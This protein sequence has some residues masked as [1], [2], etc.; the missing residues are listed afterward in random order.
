MAD[1]S[2]MQGPLR[3]EVEA[4]L[5]GALAPLRAALVSAPS[6]AAAQIDEI[7]ARVRASRQLAESD[8][9]S[10][11]ARRGGEK[12]P[13]E[14]IA[15]ELLQHWPDPIERRGRRKGSTIATPENLAEL[16]RRIAAGQSQ[17]SAARAIFEGLPGAESKAENLLKF[18]RKNRRARGQ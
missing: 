4:D 1:Q 3:L 18:W 14:I 6:E 8:P 16:E 13:S 7:A 10:I 9:K 17:K 15:D 5:A 12:L 2:W 11:W